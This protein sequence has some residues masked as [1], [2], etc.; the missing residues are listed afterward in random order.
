[1]G[2]CLKSLI[3]WVRRALHRAQSRPLMQPE[4]KLNA[5]RLAGQ[6]SF[7]TS[8][9]PQMLDEIEQGYRG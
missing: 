2:K 3:E 6:N 4:G 8:D 5:M 9:L 7:P 1:M